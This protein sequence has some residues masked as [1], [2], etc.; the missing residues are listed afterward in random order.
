[1]KEAEEDSYVGHGSVDALDLQDLQQALVM[2]S[3]GG[4][5]EFA[6]ARIVKLSRVAN[7]KATLELIIRLKKKRVVLAQ[8]GQTHAMNEG[9]L[10][11]DVKMDVGN[12]MDMA[13]VEQAVKSAGMSKNI[14]TGQKEALKVSSFFERPVQISE[15]DITSGYAEVKLRIWDLYTLNNAVRAKLRNYAYIR[16]NMHVRIMIAGTPFHYGTLLVSYQPLDLANDTLAAYGLAKVWTDD[17]RFNLFNYLSQAPGAFVMDVKDNQPAELICPY[18]SPKPM[19]RLYSTDATAIAAGSSYPDLYSAGCL[20]IYG[21][22]QV[23]SVADVFTPVQVYVYAWMTDVELGAPTASIVG[24]TTESRSLDERKTG[25]VERIATRAASMMGVLSVIPSFAPFA[26]ASQIAIS[27][28]AKISSLFGWSRPII[29]QNPQFVKNM[30]YSNGA[31]TIGS[32]TNFKIALDPHQEITVDPRSCGTDNDDMALAA[33]SAIETY[34]TTFNWTATDT[35]MVPIWRCAVTPHLQTRKFRALTG[36]WYLQ[37]TALSYTGMPFAWWRGSITYRIDIVCSAFHR[38]KIAV[39]HEPNIF[40]NVL[41]NAAIS[42]NKQ[43][44]AIIDL[45]QTQSVY[46]TVNWA[47]PRA[48]MGNDTSNYAVYGDPTVT[49]PVTAGHYNGYIGIVPITKLVSPNDSTID[50]NIFVHSKEMHY[51]YLTGTGMP[52]K[53]KIVAESRNLSV[54][55]VEEIQLNDSTASTDKISE[56]H[57]GEEPLS[58][59]SLLK[60]YCFTTSQSVATGAAAGYFLTYNWQNIPGIRCAYANSPSSAPLRTMF[61]YLRYAYLGIKGSVRYRARIL[62]TI[63]VDPNMAVVVKLS[64]VAVWA[65]SSTASSTTVGLTDLNGAVTFLINSNGGIEYEIPFY[66]NNLFALSFSEKLDGQSALSTDFM[67]QKWV[68]NHDVVINLDTASKTV[69][70]AIDVAAGEDLSFM[71]FQGAPY[72]TI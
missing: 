24:I 69:T 39:F 13:G 5:R 7:I 45:E 14:A 30:P 48:W 66:S 1:M 12:M 3:L 55:P 57:F 56:V 15:F 35:V 33:I 31:V 50:I 46:V 9:S 16:G 8:S 43:F 38:G 29:D 70:M 64:N 6:E 54:M 42:P 61:D 47:S 28:V 4:V 11:G 71:R 20:Y 19:H 53:R 2:R 10:D 68:R 72:H 52:S 37:P 26:R 23:N 18:I 44:L 62:T 21:L 34:L 58:F 67:E 36:T 63:A 51:N 40:Q 25:P 41:I 59:R 32:E 27:G 65:G 49:L 60:R 17:L 22:N